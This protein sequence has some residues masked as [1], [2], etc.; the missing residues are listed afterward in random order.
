MNS[1]LVTWTLASTG[2][3]VRILYLPIAQSPSRYPRAH[4]SISSGLQSLNTSINSNG[5][6]L[7]ASRWNSPYTISTSCR[8]FST[9]PF[10]HDASA[11]PSIPSSGQIPSVVD[12]A[13]SGGIEQ[14]ATSSQELW[15]AD[16][17]RIL[18][19]GETFSSLGLGG[20]S[21]VGLLQS[22]MELIHNTTGL[23]WWGAILVSTLC[24]RVLFLPVNFYLQKHAI[25]TH[26]V[27]PLIHKMKERQ[28][29]YMLAKN[30]DMAN[31][32]RSKM[33]AIFKEHGVRPILGLMPMLFQ[34]MVLF[35]YFMA[36]RGMAN[37]PV[38]TMMAGGALW[39]TDLTATDPTLVLP[40]ISS[41]AFLLSAEVRVLLILR[42]G[43]LSS[44]GRVTSNLG[45]C[46][47]CYC[48]VQLKWVWHGRQRKK[49]DQVL[50]WWASEKIQ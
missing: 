8:Q 50:R 10:H 4:L 7:K 6:Q 40:I 36:I 48:C 16:A 45:V 46:V 5:N 2:P 29:V 17:A 20:Y 39:F 32:E 30:L 41:A 43:A 22:S 23:P 25:R 37:A 47:F 33:N 38:T 42:G 31:Y 12:G 35:S 19:E 44:G 21:P 1:R 14:L 3:R 13:G 24:I 27:Q 26:N 28:Q 34:G 9:T 49:C 18:A 15:A 11:P